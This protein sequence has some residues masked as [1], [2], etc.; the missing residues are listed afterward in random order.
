M[1]HYTQY[2]TTVTRQNV[3]V[4]MMPDGTL[5]IEELVDAIEAARQIHRDVL[6]DSR[7]PHVP[8]RFRTIGALRVTISTVD[9][10]NDTIRLYF[11]VTER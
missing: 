3:D 2:T 10:D 7:D 5:A 4:G 8:Q 6:L 9:N 1:S 11:D